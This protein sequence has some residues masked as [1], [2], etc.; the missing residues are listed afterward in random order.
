RKGVIS[1]AGRGNL[2]FI[3]AQAARVLRLDATESQGRAITEL[4]TLP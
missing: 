4:L 1:W 3:N 2:K